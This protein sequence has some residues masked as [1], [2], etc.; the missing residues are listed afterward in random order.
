MEYHPPTPETPGS[1]RGR[2]RKIRRTDDPASADSANDVGADEPGGAKD[3]STLAK[4]GHTKMSPRQ[5]GVGLHK[6]YLEQ[7]YPLQDSFLK[8]FDAQN[9][10]QFY[11]TGG[12]ALSRFYYQ[13]RYSEDLDFFSGTEL[14]NFR[15]VLTK[16][17]DAARE[18]NFLIEVDTISDHFL[19][20]YAKEKKASLK[21]DFVNEAAFHW[22]PLNRFPAFS[23]VDNEKNIL[24][25][26]ISCISRYEVKDIVDIWVLARRLSFSWREIIDI[27]QK[28]SPVDPVEV[29]KIIKT[30]PREELKLIK[31]AFD[32]NI[33]E[34]FADLQT[35]AEDILLGHTNSLR[36]K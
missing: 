14:K 20:V 25:N 3:E 10:N 36:P 35:I 7:L 21:I 16:I 26:K 8:F 9:Q 23:C 5:G 1:A 30:L 33:N 31:W 12:T 22:G 29:S 27:A 28:K 15:E 32:V 4:T 18:K 2:R 11:L 19:R 17:L 6:F 34:V 24:S 13:H